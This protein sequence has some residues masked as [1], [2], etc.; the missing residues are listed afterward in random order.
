MKNGINNKTKFL[1]NVII[2]I[3]INNCHML[4]RD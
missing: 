3:K 4:I 1:N 2:L